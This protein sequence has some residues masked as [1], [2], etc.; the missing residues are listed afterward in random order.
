[1]R[2]GLNKL[3]D[4][5]AKENHPIKRRIDV[6]LFK[7]F[8]LK[9]AVSK[10]LPFVSE[11]NIKLNELVLLNTLRLP[12]LESEYKTPLFASHHSHISLYTC[13]SAVLDNIRM[14]IKNQIP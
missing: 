9:I 2:S 13:G 1:M 6:N 10:A 7:D 3:N 4:R 8:G 14:T 11:D 12:I 5:V